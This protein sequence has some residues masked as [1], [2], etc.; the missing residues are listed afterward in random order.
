MNICVGVS[1]ACQTKKSSHVLDAM[2]INEQNKDKIIR[3]SMSDYTTLDEC[4]YL[5]NS[6]RKLLDSHRKH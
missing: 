5:V 1:S 6:M 2:K 4:E 3:V